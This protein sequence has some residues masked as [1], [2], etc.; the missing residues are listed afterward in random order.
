VL[1]Q[2][3]TSL[4]VSESSLATAIDIA[5]PVE[6]ATGTTEAN[7]DPSDKRARRHIGSSSPP[8]FGDLK[9]VPQST[10][11]AL[12][13]TSTTST[14]TSAPLSSSTTSQNGEFFVGRP[15]STSTTQP[16][17]SS[18]TT[19]WTNSSGGS[20]GSFKISNNA[21]LEIGGAVSGQLMNGS[22][23]GVTITFDSG[24]GELILDHSAQ[25]HG[26]IAT[27]SQ[28]TP[29]TP[30]DLIDLRDLAF[31]S[32]M[33][34]SVNYD[35]TSNVS[36]VNFSNG[37]ANA[38]LLFS[39][40]DQNW[41]F[42][43][44]GQGGTIVADPPVTNP[45]VAENQLPGTPMSVWW[46]DAGDDSPKLEGFT[47]QMGTNVGGTVQ[48]K[49]DNLT[50]NPNYQISIYRLGYYGGDGA[51][52]ITTIN[53]TGSSVIAQ[54][55]PLTNA[56]TGEVDAGNWSVTDSWS[57]P[58]T[59]VSG[60]YIAN[61]TQGTQVFQIPF[62]VSDPNSTSA[63]IFQTN[64]ETW[65]AYNGWGGASVYAGNGPGVNGS[66]YAVSYNRPITTRDANA[67]GFIGEYGT[68]NAS[69]MPLRKILRK[70]NS[71]DN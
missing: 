3:S 40:N 68:S 50:G 51:R 65:Q 61:V 41:T 14:P 20:T 58:A 60:V 54:P 49:I 71:A 18:I 57:M 38:T 8:D 10:I 39:G 45:I 53:H 12:A 25:F 59:A 34:A 31:T 1:S 17:A 29:L 9:P 67:P 21:V 66:A 32:S 30:N 56:A 7:A 37:S 23:S 27:S 2:S 5:A 48:F 69:A 64:D 42:K 63:I 19:H 15:L 62:V 24:S 46:V 52:L 47:T 55:N 35:S 6:A 33:S 36:T 13:S 16:P 11:S 43:S 44:D 4:L 22:F 26:L 28:G 70:P